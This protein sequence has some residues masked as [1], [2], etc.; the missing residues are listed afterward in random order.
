MGTIDMKRWILLFVVL[1]GA[2]PFL[3]HPAVDAD[4]GMWLPTSIGHDLPIETLREMGC[5]LGPED[6]WST[7]GTGLNGAVLQVCQF[8]PDRPPFGFGSAT[9]V[10]SKGLILTNHHVAYDATAAA[11]TPEHNYVENGFQAAT[12]ADEIP[13]E[14]Q[15]VRL[16]TRFEDVTKIILEGVAEDTTFDERRK[17]VAR[18]IQA[19]VDKV[20]KEV[21]DFVEVKEMYSGRAYYLCAYDTFKDI[22][23]VNVP[24]RSIGE[25]G[26]DIDNWIWPRH[27][28]D[29]SYLRA[30]VAPD[31]SRAEYSKDNVPFEPKR[32]AK[33]SIAG[34]KPGSFCFIMGYPGR[35][36]R[37]RTSYSLDYR[38]REYYPS[39]IKALKQAIAR[40][41]EQG[42]ND[43]AVRLKNASEIKSLANTL[44]NFEGMRDGLKA[45]H[46]VERKREMEA[47][48]QEWVDA[49]P[50]R[51][52]KWGHIL[53]D[54]AASYSAPNRQAILARLFQGPVP[55]LAAYTLPMGNPSP[56]QTEGAIAAISNIVGQ[57]D[58]NGQRDILATAV[59][60][61]LALPRDQRLGAFEGIT[62]DNLD[63]K[64]AELLPAPLDRAHI[65]EIAKMSR[66]ELSSS[67]KPLDKLAWRLLEAIPQVNRAY[68]E[69]GAR[70]GALRLELSEAM[71]AF[72]N[73]PE[74]PDANS[75]LRLTY[76]TV[77][78]YSPRDAV[79]Y[80]HYTSPRGVLEKNTGKKP[81]DAPEKQ[82]ELFR[83]KDWGRWGDP[84]LNTL[85]LDF[86]SDTD[87]TGGNSGSSIMNA[88]GEMIGLAFDGNY[89]AMTSDYQFM[90]EITRTINVDIRYVL[91][92][93]EKIDGMR[94]LIEEMDIVN[95]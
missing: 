3:H 5:E 29:Y 21:H 74:Y 38:Q 32:W 82:L 37:F 62:A 52:A 11:S 78:G 7:D 92:S 20:E 90:P 34:W 2:I 47:R 87:I 42:E 39:Q 60:S 88:K 76:G 64:I 1:L 63:E 56:Q 84:D 61:N 31:G 75:T 49:D 73:Q 43:E 6:F 27:T 30:Y 66:D 55:L 14:G 41:E 4:E 54:I 83:A 50:E 91:W 28:G 33:L 35:T 44:K 85:P 26:G 79:E 12:F 36:F 24:P 19:L 17:I 71:A 80:I 81:F 45:T 23:I 8:F 51:K 57:L 59:R 68:S 67:E 40:L 53:S 46:L 10:S 86:L 95:D 89:E 15:G 16:T 13:I 93:T 58:L 18:N 48:F 77:K 65:A 94:R 69:F 70:I 22:R 72:R 25:Y 9:F